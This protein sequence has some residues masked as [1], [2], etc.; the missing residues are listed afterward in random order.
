ML[1]KKICNKETAVTFV[2]STSNKFSNIIALALREPLDLI[3]KEVNK[4]TAEANL[5]ANLHVIRMCEAQAPVPHLDQ[6]FFYGCLS[7]VSQTKRQKSAIRDCRFQ[8]T[9]KLYHSRR[10]EC[11]GYTPS[12]SQH[13]ASGFYQNV[14][15]QMVTNTRNA[16][17]GQFGR[18]LKRYLRYRHNLDKLETYRLQCDVMADTYDGSGELVLLYRQKLGSRPSYGKLEDYPYVVMPLQYEM[19][20]FFKDKQSDNAYDT[21]LRLFSLIPTKQG[22]TCSHIKARSNRLHGLL[23]CAG[24]DVPSYGLTWRAVVDNFCRELF[25]IEKFETCARMFA[26]EILTDGKCASIALRKPCSTEASRP[27]APR[28]NGMDE[29]WGLDP[30]RTDML[31]CI[32]AEGNNRHYSTRQFNAR[33][34][35]KRSNKTIEG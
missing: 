23:K 34:F 11:E 10:D 12:D 35:Y 19:L 9:I 29:I 14:S 4:A 18:R 3:T 32:N 33:A 6:S 24:F 13:L 20:Q 8:E 17:S 5:L 27:A 15:L 30:G 21:R 31:T 28:W 7:V 16:V 1:D 2:K 26:G 22:F 25:H